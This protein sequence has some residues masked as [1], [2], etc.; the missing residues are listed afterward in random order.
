[1]FYGHFEEFWSKLYAQ[2][3]R[4]DSQLCQCDTGI[5]QSSLQLNNSGTYI[6]VHLPK[7]NIG[8]GTQNLRIFQRATVGKFTC[9]RKKTK[10]NKKNKQTN[11]QKKILPI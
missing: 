7:H 3:L 6:S 8:L 1:M 11:K 4:E 2:C 9:P 10:Q 5:I